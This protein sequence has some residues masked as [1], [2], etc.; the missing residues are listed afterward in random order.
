MAELEKARRKS[1][2][3]ETLKFEDLLCKHPPGGIHPIINLGISRSPTSAPMLT[4]PRLKLH[5]PEQ[6]CNGVRFFDSHQTKKITLTEI[7]TRVFM[8]Y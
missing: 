5:C 4:K 8:H 7:W 6:F 1:V 2:Q 3:I